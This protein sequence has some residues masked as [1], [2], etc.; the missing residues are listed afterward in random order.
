M[1]PT[2]DSLQKGAIVVLSSLVIG[3]LYTLR[4]AHVQC[5]IPSGQRYERPKYT[6]YGKDFPPELEMHV[7]LTTQVFD[8]ARE[9]TLY[10]DDAWQSLFTRSNGYVRL[11]DVGQPFAVAMWHQLHC[12]DGL[13]DALKH[14]REGNMTDEDVGHIDHC[15]DYLR[16]TVRCWSDTTLEAAERVEMPDGT[17]RA[18]ATGIG[19][20]HICRDWRHVTDYVEDN[21]EIW[22]PAAEPRR[23]V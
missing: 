21:Y 12:L 8:A 7:P 5:T 2:S 1:K 14:G 3:L 4:T 19:D 16:Q 6:Y 15:L 22:Q 18:G 9:Y 10:A 20:L 13:R 11:G 23:P 17:A